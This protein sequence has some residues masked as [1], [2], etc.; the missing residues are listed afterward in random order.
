[1]HF[2]FFKNGFEIIKKNKKTFIPFHS[3]LKISDVYVDIDDSNYDCFSRT[4]YAENVSKY[5]Y[6]NIHLLD[7]SVIEIVLDNAHKSFRRYE[8]KSVKDKSWIKKLFSFNLNSEGC[9][10]E[11]EAWLRNKLFDMSEPV[12]ITKIARETLIEKFNK[13]KKD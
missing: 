13:W 8:F 6:F 7:G 1:V 3:I 2:E 4:Y 11:A 12:Y 10:K 9:D 5:A